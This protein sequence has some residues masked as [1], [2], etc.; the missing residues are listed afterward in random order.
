MSDIAYWLVEGDESWDFR[1]IH[2]VREM[3]DDDIFV[4]G[5]FETEAKAKEHIN[6]I[7]EEMQE[8]KYELSPYDFDDPNMGVI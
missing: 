5:P 3:I 8:R 2:G 4:A 1:V 7:F 6:E